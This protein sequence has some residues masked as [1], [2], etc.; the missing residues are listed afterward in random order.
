MLENTM[1]SGELQPWELRQEGCLKF[2]AMFGYMGDPRK[3]VSQCHNEAR[4]FVRS[5]K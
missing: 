2:Q 5:V 1:I 3:E 4:Y